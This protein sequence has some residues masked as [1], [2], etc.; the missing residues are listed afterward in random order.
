MSFVTLLLGALSVARAAYGKDVFAHWMLD[1]AYSFVQSDWES[2]MSTAQSI[3]IDG[4][5]LNMNA[6]DYETD[7]LVDAYAAAESLNFKLFMSFDMSYTWS[8]TDMVNIVSAHASSSAQYLWNGDVL[9]STYSGD[10][11]S[12]A[13]DSFW[14]GFKSDLASQGITISL[15]PAFTTYRDPSLASSLLSTYPSIDGFFNWWSWPADVLANLTTDTDVAYHQAI[16]ARTGPYIMGVSPWQYKDTSDDQDW[17]EY[18]DTLW[19]YRWQQA[20]D[21]QPDI[22]EIITWNDYGESHYIADVLS[23]INIG[24]ITYVDG[25]D[26]APWRDVA[27]YYISWYKNGVQPTITE[28]KVVFWYRKNPKAAVC[29]GG[30]TSAPRNAN[31]PGDSV[32]ALAMV[33][34][35]ATIS[36]DIGSSHAEFSASGNAVTMGSVPFPTEDNQIPY[37]QIIRNGATVKDG[38]GSVEVSQSCTDYNFNPFVGIVE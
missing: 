36:L 5:V 18:S 33:A 22:V 21:I 20:I 35:D 24:T 16:S 1:E 23:N 10:S 31:F 8:V 30:T 26:H 28:D 25:Q 4:F 11:G 2:D 19:N 13:T 9:V 32:F 37:I 6:N 17:V 14:S 38:Y 12:T 27:E 7:K 3:G 29:T 15:A 34:S